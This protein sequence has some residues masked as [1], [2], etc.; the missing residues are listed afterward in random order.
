M[1][2]RQQ[3]ENITRI[4]S[5]I[6][7]AR[8]SMGS[9]ES[10][11]VQRIQYRQFN[12]SVVRDDIPSV[13]LYGLASAAPSGTD[14]ILVSAAGDT[15]NVIAVASNH[16][17]IRPRNIRTGSVCLYD[18][19]GQLIHIGIE[20][21]VISIK[22]NT[23]IKIEAPTIEITGD[24]TISGKLDVAGAITSDT[25]VTAAGKHLTS[26]IHSNGNGGGNTG[27]PV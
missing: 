18:N 26:H 7:Q 15:S 11:A 17:S 8:S 25:Q 2:N 21:G 5:T 10:G 19:A 16:P 14:H 27:A 12:D 9:N 4:N 6:G 22:A 20:D 13:Q 24:V 3:R 1:S 23:K